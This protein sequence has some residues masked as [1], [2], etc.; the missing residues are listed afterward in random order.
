VLDRTRH[1]QASA[2]FLAMAVAA[3]V[4]SAQTMAEQNRE[5]S[6]EAALASAE[7]A[8]RDS[9]RADQ[10][11]PQPTVGA[12]PGWPIP[13]YDPSGRHPA[14]READRAGGS[15]DGRPDAEAL[16]DV[17]PDSSAA[18]QDGQATT[19]EAGASPTAPTSTSPD[20]SAPPTPEP[21]DT[22]TGEPT[23]TPS[24]E[25]STAPTEQPTTQPSTGGGSEPSPESGEPPGDPA[26]DAPVAAPQPESGTAAGNGDQGFAGD[27]GLDVPAES[28]TTE[29]SPV[30]GS[31][32]AEESAGG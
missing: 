30:D 19:P 1:I 21:T 8:P 9:G 27:L 32:A 24:D 28:S 18:E 3:A 4:V 20:Q 2:A 26:T 14:E 22:P 7:P 29:K 17:A 10:S 11:T 31:T 5:R 16:D 12:L 6:P 15:D 25:P 13:S 23:G